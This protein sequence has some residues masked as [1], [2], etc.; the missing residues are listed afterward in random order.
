MVS[1][2]LPWA[3]ILPISFFTAG[4]WITAII[5]SCNT[6]LTRPALPLILFLNAMLLSITLVLIFV[7]RR[8]SMGKKKASEALYAL[9]GEPRAASLAS[10]SNDEAPNSNTLSQECDRNKS[11]LPH[12]QVRENVDLFLVAIAGSLF[13]AMCFIRLCLSH[14][15]Y[16]DSSQ[17]V[18]NFD[19][20]YPAHI[21]GCAKNFDH[22]KVA[23]TNV[24]SFWHSIQ[25]PCILFY[26]PAFTRFVLLS[27]NRNM[28]SSVRLGMLVLGQILS[29]VLFGYP[30]Y[31]TIKRLTKCWSGLAS[32]SLAENGSEWAS[33]LWLG[34]CLGVLITVVY[35]IGEGG[36]SASS[37]SSRFTIIVRES[38]QGLIR[39]VFKDMGKEGKGERLIQ[40]FTILR[41]LG[42][43]CILIVTMVAIIGIGLSWETIA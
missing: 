18:A 32:S 3:S 33:G 31:N 17:S 19:F 28:S 29:L 11:A 43:V 16:R 6:N 42:V 41:L 25:G 40:V 30:I 22:P 38:N 4:F 7:L 8:S 23:F 10:S 13:S 9:P 27:W 1:T 5:A 34:L 15:F 37:S 36:G 20:G 26:F 39:S 21:E 14:Q 24:N 35:E 2:P 12:A